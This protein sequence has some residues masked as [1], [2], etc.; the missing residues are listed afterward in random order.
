[1]IVDCDGE[2]FVRAELLEQ[3][4]VECIESSC[5]HVVGL[6]S[7]VGEGEEW[8]GEWEERGRSGRWQVK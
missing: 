3:H 6:M 5:W 4:V 2:G 8:G 7:A 1:M